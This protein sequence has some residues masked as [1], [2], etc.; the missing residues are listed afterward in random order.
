[1]DDK[2]FVLIVITSVGEDYD[3]LIT[4]LD[5]KNEDE[6]TFDLVKCKLLAEYERR[7]KNNDKENYD[8]GVFKIKTFNRKYCDFCK[9]SGHIKKYCSKFD[10]WLIE[11]KKKD[12]RNSNKAVSMIKCVNS[13]ELESDEE[14][15]F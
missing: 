11:K 14:F 2:E 13:D 10:D 5:S 4:V 8:E 9:E 6:L 15:L 1:M 12:G 3:N 7:I